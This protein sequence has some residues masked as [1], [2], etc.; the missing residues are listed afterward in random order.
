VRRIAI[1]ERAD[2]RAV[3][4]SMGF[5][6]HHE[7]GERYWDERAYYAFTLE[8]IERDIETPTEELHAMCLDLVEAAMNSERL[9]DRLAIPET[10]RDYV[11][12][13]WD[14]RSPSLYG[15]F[16]FAYDGSG[17]A[18]LLEYNAD[19][20]TSI[21]ETGYF[22]WAWLEAR[23]ADGALAPDAD[24]FNSL[25][26]KL[27]DRFRALFMPESQLH[28]ASAP[29]HVEDRQTVR[30]L[31]DLA[32]QAGLAPRFVSIQDVGLDGNGRFVDDDRYI[33]QAIFKLYPWEDM[34]REPYAENL[35]KSG[36]MF[37]EPPW[38]AILSNKAILP[39]LWERHEGHPNLLPAFFADDRAAAASLGDNWVKKP[40]F[41]R[42]GWDIELVDQGRSTHGP[43]GGYGAEG[44]VLQGLAR[45]P[46]FEGNYPV[47]GSWVVGTKPAGAS[48]REDV[49]PITRNLSRFVPHAILG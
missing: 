6:W 10:L 31:E 17:P 32:A 23:I 38:K 43:S 48:I 30:Y 46:C 49:T 35:A 44:Y 12:D 14:D 2:W 24:Q 15:R 42:E 34:F 40:L 4:D 7:G 22:Q 3:A 27:V 8:Q 36:T 19:T 20:P 16:D 5:T 9:M 33:I 13:S 45:L 25:H 41:S 1:E 47:V 28:F 26:E 18:K 11:A 39:L 29:D 37:L 21:Y